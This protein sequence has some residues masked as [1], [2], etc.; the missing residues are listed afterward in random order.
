MTI[1]EGLDSEQTF[2]LPLLNEADTTFFPPSD[3]DQKVQYT[4]YQT[5]K[6]VAALTQNQ[7]P[8]IKDSQSI[9]LPVV[10][11]MG[12][13]LEL[14]DR[15]ELAC[16][17]VPKEQIENIF[18]IIDQ[19]KHPEKYSSSGS[20]ASLALLL[21]SHCNISGTKQNIARWIAHQ[22]NVPF[23]DLIDLD[24]IPLSPCI[25]FSNSYDVEAL[26]YLIREI[27]A[28]NSRAFFVLAPQDIDEVY[29]AYPNVYG[30]FTYAIELTLPPPLN[31]EDVKKVLIAAIK[32]RHLSLATDITLDDL[33]GL[34][35]GL[36]YPI[37]E[38]IITKAAC[39]ACYHFRNELTCSDLMRSIK[40]TLLLKSSENTLDDL[41]GDLIDLSSAKFTI[42]QPGDIECQ[43]SDV[44]G[45]DAAKKF[46]ETTCAYLKDPAPFDKV[47]AKGPKGILLY[48]P[49][50]TGKTMLAKAV[51][52]EAHA[53]F[54][55]VNATELKQPLIG[56]E[57]ALIRALFDDAKK[58]APSIIFIDEFDMFS[59][60]S[61]G[62]QGNAQNE[63]INALLAALDGFNE[64]DGVI[65]IAATNYLDQI[66]PALIRPGRFD[67]K[68]HVPPPKTSAREKLLKR[69]SKNH[70]IEP[71]I[72]FA[73]IAKN[74]PGATG[75]HI[76]IAWQAAACKAA[77]EG[78]EVISEALLKEA[79]DEI[80]LGAKMTA[81]NRTEKQT[82]ITAYH[83]VGHAIL[84]WLLEDY[85]GE[86]SRITITPH[87]DSDGFTISTGFDGISGHTS[88]KEL[89]AMIAVLLAGTIAE[90]LRFQDRTVGACDDLK[91]ATAI[92]RNM[93][94]LWGMSPLGNINRDAL[95]G[96][97]KE[98][99]A[100]IINKQTERV[101]KI[102]LDNKALIE[103]VVEALL[104][105]RTLEGDDLLFIQQLKTPEAIDDFVTNDYRLPSDGRNPG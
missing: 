72:N 50:G 65:V 32:K 77:M 6:E 100:A 63:G 91:K 12:T 75:A 98:A 56:L 86:I 21:Y 66:E 53:T 81:H 105:K 73:A 18:I 2:A 74:I 96:A 48:G 4:S 92:A 68:I 28:I 8:N 57:A 59:T 41:I 71:G 103:V 62:I 97:C 13:G 102:L 35:Q 10:P 79:F 88:E 23:C 89:Q 46:F 9:P 87:G 44:V 27:S 101:E 3:E 26:A 94:M 80:L 64:N 45:A 84:M 95:D 14:D 83:E 37:I 93:V 76:A 30:K 47:G 16:L 39:T 67:N 61:F 78:K 60:K 90:K 52:G 104:K 40:N 34:C 99:I 24:N 7:L 42:Y 69:Y 38:S 15:F 22:A 54:Y 82:M 31:R 51:A 11:R 33:A 58:N 36:P 49:P 43:L 17:G 20:T 1:I 5:F 85:P 70:P 25:V 19:L 29:Q 55:V